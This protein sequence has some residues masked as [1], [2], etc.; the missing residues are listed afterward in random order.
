MERETTQRE[1]KKKKIHKES[2][3]QSKRQRQRQGLKKTESYHQAPS[4]ILNP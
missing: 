3:R 1:K 4:S 2:K